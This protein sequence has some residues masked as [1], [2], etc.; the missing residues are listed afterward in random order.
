MSRITPANT[1]VLIAASLLISGCIREQR[2]ISFQQ[3]VQPILDANCISCHVAPH[4]TGYLE[5]GLSLASYGDLMKGTFYG[6]V[7]VAGD[8]R[9][10]I[11][12]MLVEGRADPSMRMPHNRSALVT[13][14][15]ETLRLWVE[16]GALDN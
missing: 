14:E 10:S 7:I 11:F 8:S 13:Q 6:P 12:N 1:A 9:H 3:D 15:I 16:Q 4:G 2:L 5:T